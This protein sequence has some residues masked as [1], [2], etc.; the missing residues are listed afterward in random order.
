MRDEMILNALA[1]D[2]TWFARKVASRLNGYPDPSACW[3]WTGARVGEHGS[4]KV[5]GKS[6]VLTHR[7]TWLALVGPIAAGLV[8]D[9]D[10]ATGCHNRACA[11]P[12]HLQAVTQWVNQHNGPLTNAAKTHC[13]NGH[14][15]GGDNVFPGLARAGRRQCRTCSIEG[16][17]RITAAAHAVGLNR[18][19]YIAAY[20]YSQQ[21]ALE[22]IA[23]NSVERTAR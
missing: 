19:D 14:L 3:E 6:S 20:G 17:R 2:P 18:L 4:V 16:S 21:V 5:P 15:L 23:T 13:R 22:L 7:A 10:G 8:L 9:H 11:N 1:A 12:A